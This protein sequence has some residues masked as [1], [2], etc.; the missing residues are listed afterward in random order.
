MAE[1]K[2]L[3]CQ[4]LFTVSSEG[5]PAQVAPTQEFLISE[6]LPVGVNELKGTS[7]GCLPSDLLA[8]LHDLLHL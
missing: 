1:S 8:V 5:R 7:H 4:Q 6:R 3:H 2:L